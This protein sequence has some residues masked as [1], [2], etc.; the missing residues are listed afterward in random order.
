MAEASIML[1]Y[2]TLSY[3]YMVISGKRNQVSS[4]WTERA[5]LAPKHHPPPGGLL[6][7]L[8]R[9]A[10]A[11]IPRLRLHNTVLIEVSLF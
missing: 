11:F 2:R 6:C 3:K 4:P 1:E 7:C 8:I 5:Y 10:I 9:F